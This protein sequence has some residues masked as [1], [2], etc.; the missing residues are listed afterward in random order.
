MKNSFL[1]RDEVV[2]LLAGIAP[3]F[4]SCSS[5]S[6]RTVDGRVVERSYFDLFAVVGG[7]ASS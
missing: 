4:F 5:E 7:A 3:F 6:T 2:G 1:S